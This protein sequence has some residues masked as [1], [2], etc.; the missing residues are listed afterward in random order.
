MAKND[1]FDPKKAID[2]IQ[3]TLDKITRPDQ[4]AEVFCNAAETQIK[5]EDHLKKVIKKVIKDDK[6]VSI[7]LNSE[8]R[9]IIA[10]DK[11]LF[12]H[13]LLKWSGLAIAYV[14]GILSPIISKWIGKILGVG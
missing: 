2:A 14:L 1:D 3:P 9:K 11:V 8:F 4:F 13:N 7:Q 5:I 10:D 12:K 6:D